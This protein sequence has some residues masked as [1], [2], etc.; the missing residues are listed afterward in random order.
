MTNALFSTVPNDVLEF[1]IGP[2]LKPKAVAEFLDLDNQAVS[3]ISS[4][5]KSSVRWDNNMPTAVRERMEEIAG[6]VNMVAN[7]FEGDAPKTAL[8]FRTRNPLLGDISPRDMVRLGRYDKLR[9]FIINS[10]SA[11]STRIR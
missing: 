9:R 3:R 11:S 7:V 2:H 10:A 5:A 1:G 4:V 8:W 6:I